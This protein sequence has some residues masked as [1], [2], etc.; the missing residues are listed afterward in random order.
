ICTKTN[1]IDIP[2]ARDS[3]LHLDKVCKEE[4]LSAKR[5]T[6]ASIT[7]YKASKNI[8]KMI[9]IPTMSNVP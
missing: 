2:P 8:N 4:I 3:H 7:I 6:I 5:C 9:K 1:A